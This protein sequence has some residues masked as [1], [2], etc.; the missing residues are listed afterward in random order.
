MRL[1]SCRLNRHDPEFNPIR[2]LRVDKEGNSIQVK[3][4][5]KRVVLDV[6]SIWQSTTLIRS[7]QALSGIDKYMLIRHACEYS[8][9]TTNNSEMQRQIAMK[10]AAPEDGLSKSLM[11]ALRLTA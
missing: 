1:F 4:G 6:F 9:N 2:L 8:S 7:R 5:G 10:K 3:E 11:A